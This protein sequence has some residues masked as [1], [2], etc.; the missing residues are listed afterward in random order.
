MIAP[1]YTIG[2]GGTCPKCGTYSGVEATIQY[3]PRREFATDI[4]EPEHIAV[5]CPTCG[6]A[7]SH[8]C[9]DALTSLAISQPGPAALNDARMTR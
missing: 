8:P 1:L 6:Y 4:Y 3:V 7:E 5:S 2:E 9:A